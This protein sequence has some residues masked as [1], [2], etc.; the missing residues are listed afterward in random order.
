MSL[1]IYRLDI[2]I[3]A[4]TLLI[5]RLTLNVDADYITGFCHSRRQLR[6]FCIDRIENSEIVVHNTG[7]LINVYDWIVQLC[8]E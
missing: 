5:E 2:P 7:E 1:K 8:E 6:S 4:T 3:Q